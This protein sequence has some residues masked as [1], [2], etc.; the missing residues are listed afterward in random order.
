MA[1]FTLAHLSDPHLPPLPAPR[2]ARSRRQARARLS[3]LD[4]QPPQ[5]PPPR[6][7]RR[8][9]GGHAGA[10]RRTTSRSPAISSI[11]RSKPNSRRRGPGWRA[12]ARRSASPS[13]PAI[14]TPMC[15]PPSIALPRRLGD[16]L[17]GDDAP[18]AAPFPF[19]APARPAGADRRILGGADAAADG[20]RTARARA[21][22]G[23]RPHPDELSAEQAFR[24]LLIH[25][26][27][28]SNSRIKRLTDSQPACSRC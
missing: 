4:P 3:Q 23:A 13:F 17:R 28:R 12:S 5:I 24:V 26:P 1:A 9:G 19:A 11:S 14:T 2:L 22:R 6:R 25:H 27:L 16:Y 7:A 20:D 21:A 18:T 8:A 10:A 15:A